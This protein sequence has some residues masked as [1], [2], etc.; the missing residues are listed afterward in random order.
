MN[1]MKQSLLQYAALLT[2][3]VACQQAPR[4][5]QQADSL[6]NAANNPSSAFAGGCF[7]RIAGKDTV[8]LELQVNDSLVTGHLTY[9]YFEKDRNSG[10]ISGIL[11]DNLLRAS[12]Q[13]ISEGMQS[14]RHAVFKVRGQQ[15]FEAMA[16]T[17][18]STGQPVFTEDP[19]QLKFEDQPLIA[20]PCTK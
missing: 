19:A 18:D 1:D 20:V 14:T 5:D 15:V 16:N 11:R 8:A 2:A 4:H 6:V 12:Y 13:Y 3:V 9:H 10:T 7:Q 17:I